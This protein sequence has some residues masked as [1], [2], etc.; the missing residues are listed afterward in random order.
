[1]NRLPI[2]EIITDAFKH[3]WTAFPLC[4]ER[5][6]YEEALSFCLKVLEAKYAPGNSQHTDEFSE[7]DCE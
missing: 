5:A 6:D 3:G 4:E 1:M 2:T 7:R